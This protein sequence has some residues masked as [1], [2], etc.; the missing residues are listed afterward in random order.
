MNTSR[1]STQWPKNFNYFLE[2]LENYEK[3]AENKC[4]TNKP[5]V[6]P[7]RKSS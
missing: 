7:K 6:Y 3:L 2:S 4:S 5:L 1:Q